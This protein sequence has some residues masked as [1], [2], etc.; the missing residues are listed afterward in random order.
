[1]D[2]PIIGKS[3]MA[4]LIFAAVIISSP[5]ALHAQ[6][7]GELEAKIPFE[8][9][10]DNTRL[11]AGDYFIRPA[12]E[13]GTTVLEIESANHKVSVFVMTINT[14]TTQAPEMSKLLFDKIGSRYFLR[15][16]VVQ[17]SMMGYD[18]Q[19]SKTEASLMKGSAKVDKHWLNV[20]H[21]GSKVSKG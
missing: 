1:M 21:H 19:Q 12:Q 11:P 2:H 16:I 10:A 9:N 3:F 8:F 14:Q 18:I 4:A 6:M 17:D 15:G 13:V 5:P 20:N 7:V